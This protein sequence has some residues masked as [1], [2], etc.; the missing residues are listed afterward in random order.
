MSVR[1]V[2]SAKNLRESFKNSSGTSN[3]SS[4]SGS[5]SSNTFSTSSGI[6]IFTASSDV[7]HQAARASLEPTSPFSGTSSNPSLSRRGSL[8]RSSSNGNL[9]RAKSIQKKGLMSKVFAEAET[10]NNMAMPDLSMEMTLLIVKRLTTKG[11]LRQ[12]QMGQSQKVIL[13]TIRMILDDDASTELSPLHRLDIHLVA[14][15]MKWAIRYS[16]ETLVTYDDYRALY[17]D[18]ERN[19]S[20]FIK[21]LPVTNRTILLDLFSLCADVTLLAHLNGM[22]LVVVAKAIS[23]SIM[24]EPERE[25]T[26]FDAS[27]QQRNLWGAA[28]EDLL[29]AFLRIKTQYDLAKIEQPDDWDEN[30]YFCSETRVLKSARQET[31]MRM[32]M[33]HHNL[34]SRLDISL[35]SSAGSS[36]PMS[37]TTPRSFANANGYFDNVLTPQS[38]SPLSHAGGVFGAALSRS[39]SLAKSNMSHSR[40][41]SPLPASPRPTSPYY[42]EE[43]TEYEE[44]MQDQSHLHRLRQENASAHHLLRPDVMM[45]QRRRSSVADM[46]SLYSKSN[47][48]EA[49]DAEE[50]YDSDPE[51]THAKEPEDPHDSLIPDFA[52]GLGWDFNRNIEMHSEELP[53]LTSF[54]RDPLRTETYLD[55]HGVT[56][57]N[58]ASSNDSGLGFNGPPAGSLAPKD[59]L[60]SMRMRHL[61]ENQ[62]N[63]YQALSRAQSQQEM[64]HSGRVSGSSSP[65]SSLHRMGASNNARIGQVL[66]HQPAARASPPLRPQRARRNSSLRRS[67]ST[68]PFSMSPLRPN[69]RTNEIYSE[70]IIL[71][72]QQLQTDGQSMIDFVVNDPYMQLP[73]IYDED[74]APARASSEFSL[75]SSPM[76][77]EGL[78][79]QPRRRSQLTLS[80]RPKSMMDLNNVRDL[81]SFTNMGVR[82]QTLQPF[83][84]TLALPVESSSQMVSSPV[85]ELPAEKAFEVLSRPKNIEVSVIFTPLAT[86]PISPRGELKSKFHE[87]FPERPISPPPGYIQGG[88]NGSTASSSNASNKSSARSNSSSATSPRQQKGAQPPNRSVSNGADK[89]RP[90]LQQSVTFS[91]SSTSS[92]QQLSVD[93]GKSKTPG[94]IRAL[95]FK[96]RNKHSDDQLKPVRINNQVVGGS[97]GPASVSVNA[98]PATAS[99]GFD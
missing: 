53:S 66:L 58:S 57:S 31:S 91:N 4:S 8:L 54:Q 76:D 46:E 77:L 42:E 78:P 45:N 29:R 22:T 81:P 5:S 39:Q 90:V 87:S 40:P 34:P 28:C 11:I 37:A 61:Q 15:A 10:E 36:M 56:R 59:K 72:P 79:I 33:P 25:F 71:H 55:K 35:P 60:A 18:Q 62:P 84:S 86:G 85:H 83:G 93:T 98:A 1:L 48:P 23:L 24:A 27:L 99:R 21:D 6:S 82:S 9:R 47:D 3:N 69:R 88:Q 73:D 30:T 13:N 94:F 20:K 51:V 43:R 95:S 96:L 64:T 32:Q 97:S 41:T 16:E 50:G 7:S 80:D 38:A 44:I 12:V 74:H 89:Q 70:P 49:P 67:M 63:L 19:F 14:H 68:D 65:Q 26:T 17:L 92:S 2:S 52:D 75:Q